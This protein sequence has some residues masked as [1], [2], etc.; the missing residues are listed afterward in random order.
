MTRSSGPTPAERVRTVLARGGTAQVAAD[1][2]PN[3]PCRVRGLIPDGAITLTAGSGSSLATLRPGATAVLELLDRSPGVC[4]SVRGLVWIRGRIRPVAA[5][6]M[7]PL[8]DDIAAT[9]PDPGLLDV[10][11][12]DLL[13]LL[14]IES[15]VF[16]DAAG[17]EDVA[18]DA[19][20]KASPDPFSTTESA[21]VTHLHRHHPELV[22]RL[23]LRLPRRMRRGRLRL[24]GLDRYGLQVRVEG[25]EGGWDS[26]I[27][28]FRTA[29]DESALC[30]AL[31]AV[32]SCPFTHGLRART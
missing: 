31:M 3:A 16:A 22:E 11:H 30:R 14:T 13:V 29:D 32:M 26:R 2:V 20:R 24:L 10:G 17:A 5:A 15:V 4:E 18:V 27:P 1:G 8:L 9:N 12:G 23:R 6:A 19:V 21:W 25:P 7:G 28:F